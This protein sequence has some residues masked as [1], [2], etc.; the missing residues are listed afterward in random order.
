MPNLLQKLSTVSITP[1]TSPSTSAETAAENLITN[2]GNRA[3]NDLQPINGP[4]KALA[5]YYSCYKVT[6]TE[7]SSDHKFIF[8]TDL[9]TTCL[10]HAILL[11]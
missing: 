5:D 1:D 11:V 6:R 7:I 4:D 2:L 3:S 9:G 8:G 10:Q